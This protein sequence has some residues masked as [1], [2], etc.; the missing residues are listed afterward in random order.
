MA[1][2][3]AQRLR[4]IYRIQE[5]SGSDLASAM[6][7]VEAPGEMYE[8]LPYP[9]RLLSWVIFVCL[10]RQLKGM[11]MIASAVTIVRIFQELLKTPPDGI[12]YEK[13][14]NICK[15]R[16]AWKQPLM[17]FEP[18]WYL[19]LRSHDLFW[20]SSTPTPSEVDKVLQQHH[21]P[22]GLKDAD[23]IALDTLQWIPHQ[24]IPKSISSLH[25]RT[26]IV[27]GNGYTLL[28]RSLGKFIDSHHVIIRINDAPLKGY[29]ND[30][31]KKTTF[32]FFFPESA[33]SDPL[34]NSDNDTVFV[35]VPFKTL[36]FLWVKEV[37]QNK[38]EDE[39]E[40]LAGFWRQ[41]PMK[42]KGKA[43]HLR[44]LNPYVTFQATFKFLQLDQWT[45]KHSTTGIIA[46]NFALHLCQELNIVGF[47]YPHNHDRTSPVHYYGMD[48]LTSE[49]ALIHDLTA[50]QEWLLKMQEREIIS[51]VL[52]P[53]TSWVWGPRP[54]W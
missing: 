42:W 8:F 13:D 14:F 3:I 33:L 44:I 7:W 23:L 53:S 43:S 17:G 4:E 15:K 46:L 31:G 30:V 40:T 21:L 27:V 49:V 48:R 51:N 20:N 6:N 41:P 9:S 1:S 5:D 16:Y 45:Q 38:E 52:H 10:R 12:Y 25:C 37:L 54:Q 32:R 39:K 50:E 26:C 29:E 28:G 36:D 22:F 18:D 35:L 34:A 47:G 19:F 24:E 11:L 2:G